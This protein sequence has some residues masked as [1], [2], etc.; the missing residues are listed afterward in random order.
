MASP[1]V[2]MPTMRPSFRAALPRTMAS[3][4]PTFQQ[5]ELVAEAQRDR[6]ALQRVLL[7]RL[8]EVRAGLA[9]HLGADAARARRGVA[10]GEQ[11]V[12]VDDVLD[13]LVDDLGLG[14]RRGDGDHLGALLVDQE[15]VQREDGADDALAVLAPQGDHGLAEAQATTEALV[16]PVLGVA[17]EEVADQ[18]ALPTVE[19]DRPL[20]RRPCQVDDGEEAVAIGDEVLA[21]GAHEVRRR[22]GLPTQEGAAPA[23]GAAR[24]QVSH[25]AAPRADRSRACPGPRAA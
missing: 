4:V 20:G 7:A 2:V 6:E 21:Q 25:R 3:Q 22:P 10:L 19:D 12:R 17:L 9:R 18:G 11:A 24:G 14:D 13:A 5:V 23:M 15:A 1:A 8:D 16:R